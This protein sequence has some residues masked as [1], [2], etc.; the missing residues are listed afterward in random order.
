MGGLARRA[1]LI[2]E[3][4]ETYKNVLLVDAGDFFWPNKEYA[5]LRAEATAAAMQMMAYDA[6]NV[7][8]GELAYGA[9]ALQL[10]HPG[11]KD[12]IVSS[13]LGIKSGDNPWNPY[14]TQT[15]NDIDI[16]VVGVVSPKLIRHAD[17][18]AHDLQ[19][20]D[21]ETTLK[22]LIPALRKDH[23]IV[24][25]LSHAGWQQSVAWI[26]AVG[27]IDFAVVGHDYYPHFEPET[28]NQTVLFKCAIGGKY[29][30]IIKLWRDADGRFSRYDSE[31][32]PL[33]E[34][35]PVDPVFT[36][37]EKTYERKKRLGQ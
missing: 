32:V 3:L 20:R 5:D 23:D 17:P 29:L 22:R 7:A 14:L 34:E 21:A 35:I 10:L 37:P 13:N 16:A 27:G 33:T 36:G 24:L 12:R 30:G 28:V 1:S 19:T 2:S 8:D 6:V 4:R 9:D 15:I 25:L 26:E 31:L 18:N 11:L